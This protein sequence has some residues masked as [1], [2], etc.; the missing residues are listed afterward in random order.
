MPVSSS[1]IDPRRAE[2]EL[3]ALAGELTASRA[4][5]HTGPDACLRI[6]QGLGR[7]AALARDCGKLRIANACKT[8]SALL[9]RMDRNQ[10]ED[11]AFILSTALNF[12]DSLQAKRIREGRP[13]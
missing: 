2:A 8:L 11:A 9:A 3:L 12:L 1:R 5:S 10:E 7:I 6:S 4:D 13:E